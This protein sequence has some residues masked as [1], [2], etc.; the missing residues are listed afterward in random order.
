MVLRNTHSVV[1][2]LLPTEIIGMVI[3]CSSELLSLG[4]TNSHLLVLALGSHWRQFKSLGKAGLDKCTS[5]ISRLWWGLG[6][7]NNCLSTE[8]LARALSRS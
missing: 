8:L 4:L 6:P 3:T 1:V 5:T 7:R 2:G